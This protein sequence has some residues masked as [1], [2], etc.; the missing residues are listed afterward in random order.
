ML[1]TVLITGGTGNFG[2][3]LARHF[4]Q[5]GWFVLL[6]SRKEGNAKRA[7]K[8]LTDETGRDAIDGLVLDLRDR[9]SI[10]KLVNT[11]VRKNIFP[12]ALI[13]N[14]AVDNVEDIS[15]L[16]YENLSDI[17]SVNFTGTAWLTKKIIEKWRSARK[18]GS[19]INI[20]SLLSVLGSEKSSAYAASK[21]ALES[22]SRCVAVETGRDDIRINTVRIAGMS[23][24]LIGQHDESRVTDLSYAEINR[25][26]DFSKVPLRRAGNYGEF[27]ELVLFLASEHSSYITGQAFNVDGGVSISYPGYSLPSEISEAT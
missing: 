27:C 15:S 5:N 12:N 2:I 7:V 16:S 14:S 17:I 13:N 19:I 20:S 10:E 8:I 3:R 6:T 23:G 4:L 22:F 1:K 11:L 24:N 26:N 18:A 25:K 21:A 9:E